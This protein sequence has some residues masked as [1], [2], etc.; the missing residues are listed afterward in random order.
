MKGLMEQCPFTPLGSS[1][2]FSAEKQTVTYAI[3]G[4]T[5]GVLRIFKTG[6]GA[7][8]L[9]NTARCKPKEKDDLEEECE[10]GDNDK[11]ILVARTG[12]RSLF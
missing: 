12:M 7:G 8:M 5:G 6:G 9:V 2:H 4:R 1:Q 11:T 10:S 3:D